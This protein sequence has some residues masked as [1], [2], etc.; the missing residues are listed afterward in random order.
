MT[1][2]DPQNLQYT[3]QSKFFAGAPPGTGAPGSPG[4]QDSPPGVGGGAVIATPRILSSPYS[5]SQA[6]GNFVSIPVTQ[7][8]TSG[9]TSDNPVGAVPGVAGTE[10]YLSTGA[11]QGS[12]EHIPH[13]NS[14]A[15][16]P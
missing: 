1:T 14:M 12:G 13:P 3:D 6:E 11:G 2:P 10:G 9:M 7:G 5:S 4:V 8:D 16:R 15:R